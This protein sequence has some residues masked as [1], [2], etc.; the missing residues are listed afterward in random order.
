MGQFETR[1]PAVDPQTPTADLTAVD[2][3]AEA[4][5]IPHDPL[6]IRAR[7]HQP[8]ILI[9][10]KRSETIPKSEPPLSTPTSHVHPVNIFALSLHWRQVFQPLQ[11]HAIAAAG[12]DEKPCT[13][14]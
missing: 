9:L 1:F 3:G 12:V 5:I 13:P 7:Q 4:H 6:V 10:G 8:L 2:H 11:P 14:L